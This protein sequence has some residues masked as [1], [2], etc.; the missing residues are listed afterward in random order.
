MKDLSLLVFLTQ[1]G[2]SVVAPLVVFIGG[3]VWLYQSW[4]WG[5]WVLWVGIGLGVICAFDGFINTVKLMHRLS[6]DKKD[7]QTPPISFNDHD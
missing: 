4:N 3:A 2:L 1:L 7:K 5:S 6:K